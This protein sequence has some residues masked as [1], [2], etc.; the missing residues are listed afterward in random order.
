VSGCWNVYATA[1]LL[2]GAFAVAYEWKALGSGRWRY[3]DRVPV[4]PVL[5]AGLWPLLQ[6][7]LL[8]PLAFGLARRWAVR[9]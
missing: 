4:M 5:G 8:V 9:R 1:A 3:T 6:L 2:G 7:A